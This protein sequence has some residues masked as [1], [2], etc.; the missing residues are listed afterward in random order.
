[1]VELLYPEQSDG[2][3]EDGK[4][5]ERSAT[6]FH[7]NT[8]IKSLLYTHFSTASFV[9]I[10]YPFSETLSRYYLILLKACII[11]DSSV[12]FAILF[13]PCRMRSYITLLIGLFKCR[14]WFAHHGSTK[15]A[16]V[17]PQMPP[18]GKA[19]A[20]TTRSVLYYFQSSIPSDPISNLKLVIPWTPAAFDELRANHRTNSPFSSNISTSH[21]L[22]E[23][24]WRIWGVA[25]MNMLWRRIIDFAHRAQDVGQQR[26]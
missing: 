21:G 9:V 26:E 15:S 19:A 8:T 6:S 14:L 3:V 4:M 10:L 11:R 7:W 12:S 1:M 2:M 20:M 22:L 23:G 16:A 24:T 5:H 13:F 18:Y 25:Q 17:S